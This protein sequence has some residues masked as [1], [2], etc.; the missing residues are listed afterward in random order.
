MLSLII[1]GIAL[2]VSI[3]TAVFAYRATKAAETQGKAAWE[4]V[5]LQRPRPVITVE[6]IWNLEKTT[7]EPD[8]FVLRNLGSSPA[9][10]IQISNIEGPLLPSVKYQELLTTERIYAIAEKSDPVRANHYRHAAVNVLSNQAALKFFQNAGQTFPLQDDDG[11]V[12]NHKLNFFVEY[13][14]L[15]GKRRFRTECLICFNLGFPDPRA[16][17]IPASDWLGKEIH[18]TGLAK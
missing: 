6:G 16:Q 14:A 3:I 2:A 11:N 12:L 17:I 1:S 10:D 9:F 7:G 13:S 18:L 5:E 4:Q 15:D 8:G